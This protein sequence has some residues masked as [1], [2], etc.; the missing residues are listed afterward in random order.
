MREQR[1]PVSVDDRLERRLG[2]ESRELGEPLVAL[3][4]QRHPSQP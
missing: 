1:A 3:H 4:P 2:P